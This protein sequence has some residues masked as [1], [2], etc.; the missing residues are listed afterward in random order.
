MLALLTL[1]GCVDTSSF[2]Q[3]MTDAKDV[4]EQQEQYAKTQPVPKFGYSRERAIYSQIYQARNKNIATHT[5]WRGNTSIIEGDCPSIGFPIPYDVQLTNP[6]KITLLKLG[7]MDDYVEGVVEQAEP[8][9]LFSS[10]TTAATWVMCAV[11]D[12][13]IIKMTPTYV[14]GKVTA[15]TYPVNVDYE[16]NRVHKAHGAKPS[17]IITGGK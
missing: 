4:N 2:K 16:T 1:I 14:E 12:Q 11:E 7:R 8:N 6:E 17:V 9:G 15:Y 5:V 3:E 10:K 13:G